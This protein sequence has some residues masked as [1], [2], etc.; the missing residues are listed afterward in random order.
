MQAPL[1]L[2]AASVTKGLVTRAEYDGIIQLFCE[3]LPLESR[4]RV[5]M[6][7]LLQRNHVP[8]LCRKLGRSEKTMALLQA[9]AQPLPPLWVA[10]AEQEANHAAQQHDPLLQDHIEELELEEESC[11]L[12]TE[13]CA[14]FVPLA[15]DKEDDEKAKVW[16]LP[17]VPEALKTELDAYTAFRMEPLQ[18]Q[19]L[20]SCVVDT[21]VGSDKAT[22]MRFL[23]WLSAERQITLGLGVFC[24]AA[25]SQ[26]VED[27]LRALAEK[28]LKYSTLANYCVSHPS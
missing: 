28:G 9:L 5:R 1:Q 10:Q 6:C 26:W 20:G 7:T 11:H 8:A 22:T 15:A 25:L 19:R 16:T 17:S 18:R 3:G 2:K 12:A 23:G 14:S 21:T 4:G 27:Y 13:L 24:R